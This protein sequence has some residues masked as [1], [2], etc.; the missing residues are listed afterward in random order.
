MRIQGIFE[1]PKGT[2]GCSVALSLFGEVRGVRALGSPQGALGAEAATGLPPAERN[3]TQLPLLPSS[4]AEPKKALLTRRGGP[5][6]HLGTE[7]F[8]K[9]EA[10]RDFQVAANISCSI[11]TWAWR[12]RR[13]QRRFLSQGSCWKSPVSLQPA[14]MCQ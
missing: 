2:L 1:K 7:S 5:T 14:E 4:T 3:N 12:L 6:G 8:G 9:R 10:Q 13:R 11:R